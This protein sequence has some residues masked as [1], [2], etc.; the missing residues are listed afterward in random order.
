MISDDRAVLLTEAPVRVIDV[1]DSSQP[2]RCVLDVQGYTALDLQLRV[3]DGTNVEV[4]LLTS[5]QDDS[6][7]GWIE[8]DRFVPTSA[9]STCRRT[10]FPLLRYAR[11]EMLTGFPGSFLIQGVGRRRLGFLPTDLDN[12]SVRLRGDRGV[13]V[14]S[15][16]VSAW[17]DK[18]GCGNNVSQGTGS[19]RPTF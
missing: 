8:V 13:T 14:V 12:C 6:D 4:R 7:D 9:G 5:M 11:W 10:F 17:A 15:G 1:D 18:S 16:A 3:F 19:K 2:L